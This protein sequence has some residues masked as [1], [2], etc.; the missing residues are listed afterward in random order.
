MVIMFALPDPAETQEA[1]KTEMQFALVE[2]A[3]LLTGVCDVEKSTM[4]FS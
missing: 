2:L 3:E 4:I 1:D